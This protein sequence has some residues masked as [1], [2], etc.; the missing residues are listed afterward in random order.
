MPIRHIFPDNSDKNNYKN[1]FFKKNKK[2]LD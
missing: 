1:L 2:V